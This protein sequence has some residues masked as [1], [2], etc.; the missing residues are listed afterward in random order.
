MIAALII[1]I[2]TSFAAI[3][4]FAGG[5]T[6]DVCRIKSQGT[7]KAVGVAVY[8]DSALTLP[9]TEI[10]WG[11][12]EPGGEK[13]YTAYF[14]NESNVPT[15]LFLTTD[16]WSPLNVSSFIALTWD[17]D[18]QLLEVDVFVE[19]T[20]TLAVDPAISGVETFSFDIVIVGSG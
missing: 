8:Q 9:L 2:V 18:G 16:N 11:I 3:F 12:V 14:K 6:S 1:A 10:N 17:Y 5:I 4:L 13:N 15:T 19:A 7:I 20:F